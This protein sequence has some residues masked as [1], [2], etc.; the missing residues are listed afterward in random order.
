VA[1]AGATSGAGRSGSRNGPLLP[2]PTAKTA[3][4]VIASR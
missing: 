1:G 4:R 2:Q 3:A